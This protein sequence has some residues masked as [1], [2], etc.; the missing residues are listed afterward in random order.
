MTRFLLILALFASVATAA[1]AQTEIG[2]DFFDHLILETVILNGEQMI[3]GQAEVQSFKS[4]FLSENGAVR[5]YEQTFSIAVN[6][7]LAYEIGELQTQS[8]PFKVMF[9]KRKDDPAKAMIELL[10][11]VKK[12]NPAD[13]LKELLS[14]R[15]EWMRLCNAHEANELVRKLYTPNAYYYNRGRLLT[16]TEAISAEYSYMNSANYSLKLTPKHVEF[17]SE[18]LAYELGRCSGSYPLPYMLLWQKQANGQWQV[19][20]DSNY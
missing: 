19:L 8:G 17:V 2:A 14:Q 3:K 4:Q 10:V 11:I 13:E 20:M 16:G 12:E 15:N 9:S 6:A 5:A 7:R 1:R 18:N